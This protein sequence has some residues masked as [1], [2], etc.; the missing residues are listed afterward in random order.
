MRDLHELL[1]IHLLIHSL[2]TLCCGLSGFVCSV[3]MKK[4]VRYATDFYFHS[5]RLFLASRRDKE[6]CT[7][8]LICVFFSVD[9][10][11]DVFILLFHVSSSIA[12][13]LRSFHTFEPLELHAVWDFVGFIV[14]KCTKTKK[15]GNHLSIYARKRATKKNNI[16]FLYIIFYF[17]WF[18]SFPVAPSNLSSVLDGFFIRSSFSCLFSRV[19]FVLTVQLCVF[20][21]ILSV[22]WF[23]ISCT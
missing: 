19:S 23:T 22:I 5:F 9:L 1:L 16:A 6:A 2:S 10:C 11:H 7:Y 4:C 15:Y 21:Y 3:Y 12:C 14:V 17:W 8:N 18:C 20:N 13:F